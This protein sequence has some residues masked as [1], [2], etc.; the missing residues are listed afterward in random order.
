M[1]YTDEEHAEAFQTLVKEH[2]KATDKEYFTAYY[3]LTADPELRKKAL[4]FVKADGI[5]WERIRRQ[6]W[7][8]GYR[9]LLELTETL[10]HSEGEAR[11]AYGLGTWDDTLYAVALQSIRMRREGTEPNREGGTVDYAV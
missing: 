11:L 6:D 1:F 3:V 4:R 2:K 7:S 10:F 5:E 9:L 8:S